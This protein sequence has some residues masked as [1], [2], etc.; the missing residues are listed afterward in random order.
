MSEYSKKSLQS[1]SENVLQRVIWTITFICFPGVFSDAQEIDSWVPG[2]SQPSEIFDGATPYG[3]G[4]SEDLP[5]IKSMGKLV[6]IEGK[7]GD[8]GTLRELRDPTNGESDTGAELK[9][10][11][12]SNSDLKFPK[13]SY[14]AQVPYVNYRSDEESLSYL[15]GDG[16]QFGWLS[17]ESSPYLGRGYKSGITTAINIHLLSGP[18]LVPLPPRLYDFSLGYQKRGRVKD[19]LSYDLATSIGVFSDFEDMHAKAYDFLGMRSEC[20]TSGPNSI[21]FSEWIT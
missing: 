4:S 20:F 8:R 19:Y 15:P 21:L 17:F 10:D 16:D 9:F 18:N 3:H 7:S 12:D 2:Q 13:L 14:F 1:G 5:K 11:P 6:S